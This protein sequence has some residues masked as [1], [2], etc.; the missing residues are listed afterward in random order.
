MAEQRELYNM[1]KKNEEISSSLCTINQNNKQ[2]KKSKQSLI[3]KEEARYN[4]LK[5]F[6]KI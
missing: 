5:H 6:G 3:T 4:L 2:I 1:L